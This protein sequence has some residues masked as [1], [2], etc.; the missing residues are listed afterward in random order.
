M[1]KSHDLFSSDLSEVMSM[2]QPHA[3]RNLTHLVFQ[4]SWPRTRAVRGAKPRIR[5]KLRVQCLSICE[6]YTPI[7][8]VGDEYA[9]ICSQALCGLASIQGCLLKVRDLGSVAGYG[10]ECLFD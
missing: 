2:S 9:I 10:S 4:K 8:G 6:I 5:V 7:I 1:V 3:G